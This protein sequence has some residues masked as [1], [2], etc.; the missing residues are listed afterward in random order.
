MARNT[1]MTVRSTLRLPAMH[2]FV[3]STV[4]VCALLT[5]LGSSAARADEPASAPAVASAASAVTQYA[6]KP[7]QS[8]NDVAIA[9]TQSHDRAVLARAAK[10][11]FDANPSAFMRG[12]P[13]LMKLGAVLNVPPLDASGAPVPIAAPAS[14]APGAS[15]GAAAT[16]AAA[17]SSGAA[18][19]APASAP[20]HA[21]ASAASPAMATPGTASA[22]AAATASGAAGMTQ[23]PQANAAAASGS[24]AAVGTTGHAWTGAI[25]SG[26]SS[27]AQAGASSL[28]ESTTSATSA[29]ASAPGNAVAPASG[30]ASA[31]AAG[32]AV[33]PASAASTVGAPQQRFS[34]LQQLLALKNRVLMDLQRHGFGSRQAQEAP[35]A[36]AANAASGPAV[37]AAGGS[38]PQASVPPAPVH[39][40]SA[41]GSTAGE[42]F[43]GVGDYGIR[44][45]RASIPVVAAVASAVV[46]A[47][48]VLLV[49]FSIGSRKR[50]A[51]RAAASAEVA[52]SAGGA[53]ARSAQ[54]SDDAKSAVAEESSQDPVAAEFL[55]ALARNPTSKR[56]L[57]GLAGH[58]AERRNVKGFDEIAQRIWHLSGGHGPNWLHIASIG[59]QLD[60]DNPLFALSG[61]ESD[62]AESALSDEPGDAAL[63]EHSAAA[64]QQSSANVDGEPPF[65]EDV[66]PVSSSTH[67][68]PSAAGALD[69]AS[70]A[71]PV[72]DDKRP[73]PSAGESPSPTG[74]QSPHVTE[75]NAST[76]PPAMPQH[77]AVETAARMAPDEHGEAADL[78][79]ADDGQAPLSDVTEPEVP[80]AVLP[81]DAINALNDLDMA[82]PP[83]AAGHG[84]TGV[85]GMAPEAAGVG[86]G[87]EEAE[88]AHAAE[89]APEELPH[90]ALLRDSLAE[91]KEHADASEIDSAR[92]LDPE[93]HDVDASAPAADAAEV[94][95]A[96]SA[97]AAPEGEPEAEPEGEPMPLP[98]AVAG[99]GA[100]RFGGLN[101]AFDLNLPGSEQGS[102]A[103]V[104][105][106]AQPMFSTEEIAKIAR[107]KLEL[108]REYIALGDLGGARTL[109]HEVIESNDAGTRDDA[110]A[111]LATLAPLS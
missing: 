81:A 2:V 50:R 46:A 34:S 19:G 24:Q 13:S 100:A 44:I 21:A 83:R 52:V 30:I 101:L 3:R 72:E 85:H 89:A 78:V 9:A 80:H 42:S 91:R 29:P 95:H 111:L 105:T 66:P 40:P 74:E 23:R 107:N 14:S 28:N 55:S 33:A 70:A 54:A 12:D 63:P 25:Q 109:I 65:A 68:Q 17:A 53:P 10:A 59:R 106:P 22:T 6:V 4:R 104:A 27:P 38:A 36:S 77:A 49:G 87:D 98:A 90:D 47:L 45:A 5:V 39:V 56:A 67:E 32:T 82:L 7:G 57:M 1:F 8:L 43:I 16:A 15:A 31:S 96:H 88:A 69:E 62:A 11:I 71:S 84:Q 20:Q 26:A 75:D 73:A 110:H 92:S 102:S 103:T 93:P 76:N 35:A 64:Q 58:Y 99:L 79:H 97:K 41:R 51:A 86:G 18:A 37:A 94:R 108:A 60:P 61:E 48:L